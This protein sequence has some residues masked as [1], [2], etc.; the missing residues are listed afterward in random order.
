MSSV[1]KKVCPDCFQPLRVRTSFGIHELLREVYMECTNIVCGASFSG[2]LEITHRLSPPSVA[3]PR[4][5]LPMA[6]SALR[7]RAQS[8]GKADGQMDIDDLLDGSEADE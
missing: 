7:R 2:S 3:N 8:S 5:N 6:D 4:I 1:Y